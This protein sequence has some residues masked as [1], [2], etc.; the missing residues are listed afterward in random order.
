MGIGSYPASE[1]LL[2]TDNR[3]KGYI[4]ECLSR[5]LSAI[6]TGGFFPNWL[7]GA[8]NTGEFFPGSLLGLK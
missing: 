7:L 6:D 3:G 5:L 4:V 1:S 8:I 2:G